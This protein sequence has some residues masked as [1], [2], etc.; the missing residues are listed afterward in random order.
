M[1]LDAHAVRLSLEPSDD[2]WCETASLSMPDQLYEPAQLGASDGRAEGRY[3]VVP[4]TFVVGARPALLDLGNEPLLDHPRDRAVERPRTE[5]QLAVGAC[6]DVLHDRV[7]MT[8]GFGDR[9]QDVQRGRG[10]WEEL[11]RRGIGLHVGNGTPVKQSHRVAWRTAG[12][13]N[14]AF[15]TEPI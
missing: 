6:R 7:T 12:A 15:S 1:T 4:A 14:L 11:F 8:V 3:A 10:Q 13:S 5:A 9:Q 2:A